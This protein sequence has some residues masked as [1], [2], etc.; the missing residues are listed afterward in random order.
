M[1]RYVPRMPYI[2]ASMHPLVWYLSPIAAI[3]HLH[4]IVVVI[5]GTFEGVIAKRYILGPAQ[6]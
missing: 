5:V 3:V 2:P 6:G 1:P 4:G